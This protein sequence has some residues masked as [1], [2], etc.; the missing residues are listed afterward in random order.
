M[1]KHIIYALG[2]LLLSGCAK[3]TELVDPTPQNET[4]TV[5]FN[6]ATEQP[7][8]T[9]RATNAPLADIQLLLVNIEDETK[10]YYYD[11]GSQ[12]FL[13][14][15]INPGIYDIYASA[16]H[17]EKY[18]SYSVRA[19]ASVY[20]GYNEKF[21]RPAMGFS[22]RLDLSTGK[23]LFYPIK[24]VPTVAKLQVN[25]K[26]VSGIT[27]TR[28][29]LC[30]V[31]W[32]APLF[33][34]GKPD[35]PTSNEI[36]VTPTNGAFTA[37]VPEN[38]QGTV[39]SI[40]DQKQRTT[41]NAPANATYLKIEGELADKT[42]V[43]YVVYLGGNTTDDFNVRRNWDYRININILDAST[44]DAR[45]TTYKA[46]HAVIPIYPS[47]DGKYCHG[48]VYLNQSFKTSAEDKFSP[49]KYKYVFTGVTPGKLTL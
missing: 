41:A 45:I 30:S 47:A 31:R 17:S 34:K 26:A 20:I 14:A 32:R 16:N 28:M 1:K 3:E 49:I 25:V 37:Y 35:Y 15:D 43:E 5:T 48:V 27:I 22:D 19:L 4:T 2:A 44:L 40:T 36:E 11:L 12:Q 23:P 18:G 10:R 21:D 13:V 6:F 29:S 7:V 8:A 46:S 33:P 42:H 9:T 38:L 24:L 39:A